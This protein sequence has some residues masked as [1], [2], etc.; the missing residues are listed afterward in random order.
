MSTNRYRITTDDVVIYVDAES[1]ESWAITEAMADLVVKGHT[2][3]DIYGWDANPAH[4]YV[5]GSE[6]IVDMWDNDWSERALA[7]GA[8]A[9]V[10]AAQ[11][12]AKFQ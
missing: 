1:I 12:E 9:L 11:I 8:A 10:R 7:I 2:M 4:V 3:F 6:A 5:T